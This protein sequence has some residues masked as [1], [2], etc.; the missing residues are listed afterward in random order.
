MATTDS[1]LSVIKSGRDRR[2]ISEQRETSDLGT[3]QN[4]VEVNDRS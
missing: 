4:S 2:K 1:E 3:T